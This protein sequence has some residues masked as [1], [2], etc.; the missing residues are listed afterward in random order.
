MPTASQSSMRFIALLVCIYL[1]YFT[2]GIAYGIAKDAEVEPARQRLGLRPIAFFRRGSG[3]KPV[4]LL[5]T[6]GTLIETYSNESESDSNETHRDQL[7]ILGNTSQIKEDQKLLKEHEAAVMGLQAIQGLIMLVFAWLYKTKVVNNIPRLETR[8]AGS[9]GK[10]FTPPL[11]ACWSNLHLCCHIFCCGPC[12]A[13]HSWHVAGAVDYVLGIILQVL[14]GP[15]ACLVGCYLR[16]K[17]RTTIGLESDTFMDFLKWCCCSPCAVGQEA[18]EIDELSEVNVKCCCQLTQVDPARAALVVGEPV[19]GEVVQG[20]VV[21]AEG[22][23][24]AP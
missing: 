5:A 11:C 2:H 4:H 14:L 1:P 16:G 10:D 21:P 6:P 24:D 13:A 7:P 9:R 19:Q 12:R 8:E 15:C 23:L 20:T 18:M 3:G 17:M 22:Q